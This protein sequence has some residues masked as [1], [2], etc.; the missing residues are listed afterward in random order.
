MLGLRTRDG[1]D[2]SLLSTQRS[3]DRL[4]SE[5]LIEHAGNGLRLTHKGK[6]IADLVCA[7]LVRD[8]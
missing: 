5:N 2:V 1:I 6:H 3:A 8:L 7:E 4:V